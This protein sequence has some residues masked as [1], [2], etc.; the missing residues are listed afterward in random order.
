MNLLLPYKAWN[1][2]TTDSLATI[3]VSRR[4]LLHGINYCQKYL[5]N[6]WVI[7][8]VLDKE[9]VMNW[10]VTAVVY[11]KRLPAFTSKER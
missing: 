4:I 5:E 8:L 11:F 3:N 7:Y 10:K 2:L 9:E 1:F 6:H